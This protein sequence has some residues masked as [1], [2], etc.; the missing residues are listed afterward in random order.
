MLVDLPK[1]LAQISILDLG[2]YSE[3]LTRQSF[4]A[5]LK[6]YLDHLEVYV[7]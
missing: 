6:P 4:E 3:T 5:N 2:K 7:M 1:E